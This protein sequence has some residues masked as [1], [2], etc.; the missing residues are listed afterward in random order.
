MSVDGAEGLVAKATFKYDNYY[1]RSSMTIHYYNSHDFHGNAEDTRIFRY[2]GESLIEDSLGFHG[3]SPAWF[4][5]LGREH[6]VTQ[7]NPFNSLN[8]LVFALGGIVLYGIFV[9]FGVLGENVLCCPMFFCLFWFIAV[10]FHEDPWDPDSVD[11][12]SPPL[13]R[14]HHYRNL[15][16]FVPVFLAAVGEMD[17]LQP[18]GRIAEPAGSF[19]T[20]DNLAILLVVLAIAV[21][22]WCATT[23]TSRSGD[24]GDPETTSDHC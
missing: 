13:P 22:F 14:V 23:A 11:D 9:H 19:W 20:V 16:N 24:P 17:S 8:P 4:L 7:L 3:D 15:P 5:N 1:R 10:L 2:S 12:S 21:F 18:H 6:E